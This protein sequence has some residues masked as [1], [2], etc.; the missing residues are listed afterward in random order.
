MKKNR[1]LKQSILI[2]VCMLLAFVFLF[3]III[4]LFNSFKSLKE[5]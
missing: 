3:P 4:L 5:I 2:L 1:I